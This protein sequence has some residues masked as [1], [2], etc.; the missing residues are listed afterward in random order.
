MVGQGVYLDELVA[1]RA[2]CAPMEGAYV[3]HIN[4]A[5]DGHVFDFQEAATEVFC[6]RASVPRLVW[7]KLR[8]SSVPAKLETEWTGL[9]QRPIVRPVLVPYVA[10]RY[11]WGYHNMDSFNNGAPWKR[12]MMGPPLKT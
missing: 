7:L 5:G 8:A 12:Q 11:V 10:F 2:K 4:D 1:N 3:G 6:Q 9:L